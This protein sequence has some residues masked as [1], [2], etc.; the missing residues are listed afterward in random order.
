MAVSRATRSWTQLVLNLSLL[1]AGL[2]LVQV[3][4]DRANVQF[5]LTPGRTLSLAP[6]TTQ[7]LGQVVEPMQVTVFFRRGDRAQYADIARR[8]QQVNAHVAFE[9]LDFDR[10]PERVRS[11]GVSKYGTAAIEYHG[12]R[13]I[14]PT[15]PEEQ[16]AGGILRALRGR[17]RRMAFSTGHGERTP[18]GGSES[19][20]RLTGALDAENWATEPIALLDGSVPEGIDLVVVAG[21]KHDF[22]RP[23]LVALADFLRHGGGVLLLLDPGPLPEVGGFLASLGIVLGDDV[24]VDRERKLLG[25]DGMAAVVEEFRPGNPVTDAA[26]NRLESG[27]VL[28]S[29]RSIGVAD[30]AP[31][32]VAVDA[33][34]RTA[35]TAWAMADLDRARRGDEP[36]VAKHDR[37][38]PV[39]IAAM[40]EVGGAG[41]DRRGRVVVL[42]D[43]D[44][45]SDAYLDLLGN[46]DLA[47][48]AVAWVG[49]EEVLA[50]VRKK[51]VPE[52]LRPLSP[53]VLTDVQAH[54][55][56]V[57]AAIVPPVLVLATGMVVVFRRRRHG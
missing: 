17:A 54:R 12:R 39:T 48:N 13:T 4:A 22:L 51:D 14:A 36:S 32:G 24:V 19:F 9:L 23:E 35:P 42:G 15:L 2:A 8:V 26:S 52:V 21:P 27:V 16:L 3:A 47:L 57:S 53:L 41:A 38:G 34:A 55:I 25:T 56:L 30:E 46:R 11:L 43:A 44:F 31:P 45:A 37:R 28:P 7:V 20:G 33:I 10:N 50:G 29:A 18:A 6:V 1:L 49:G 5:D 40:A